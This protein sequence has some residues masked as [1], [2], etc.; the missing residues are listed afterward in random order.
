MAVLHFLYTGQ[1]GWGIAWYV[2]DTLIPE[3]LV[4]RGSSYTFIIEGGNDASIL[5]M[6]HPFYITN[7][8]IGGRVRNTDEQKAV[9]SWVSEIVIPYICHTCCTKDLAT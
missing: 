5:A 2:N 1:A 3:L 8:K 9:S 4:R 7:S 6:Y